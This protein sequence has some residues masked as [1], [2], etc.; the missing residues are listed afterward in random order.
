MAFAS[1]IVERAFVGIF[2]HH[3][4]ITITNLGF[5]GE[6]HQH[7]LASWQSSDIFLSRDSGVTVAVFLL[8]YARGM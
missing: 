5:Q 6:F 8:I 7:Q 1:R 2:L 4:V 3:N